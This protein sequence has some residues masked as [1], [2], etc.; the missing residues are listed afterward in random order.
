MRR[1]RR[2][3]SFLGRLLR[4]PLRQVPGRV[5][6]P[7]LSGPLRGWK[8][9]VGSSIRDCWLGSYEAGKQRLF[10]RTVK[11]GSIVFDISSHVGFYS[12][13][14]SSRLGPAGRV[15][16]F[17]PMPRNLACLREHLRINGVTNVTIIEKAVADAAGVAAFTAAGS[18]YEGHLLPGGELQIETVALDDLIAQGRLPVP[19][20]LKIDVEG[21]EVSVLKGAKKL[22]TGRRPTIFLATHAMPDLGYNTHDPCCQLLREHGY[23]LTPIGDASDEILA[24]HR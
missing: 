14:A 20:L 7:V 10:A 2:Q 5:R 17:E 23:Q 4:L 18:S 12:L 15:F 13:L 24:E 6:K 1:R 11:P 19:D 3:R 8:W 21:A 9:V 22:L 16:A